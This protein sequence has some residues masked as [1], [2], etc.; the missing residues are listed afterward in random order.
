VGA[1]IFAGLAALVVT[2]TG[3]ALAL[4]RRTSPAGSRP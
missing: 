2:F 1:V 4:L 3:T